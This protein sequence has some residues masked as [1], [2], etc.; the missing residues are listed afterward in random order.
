MRTDLWGL[1]K[2]IL[3]VC[4]LLSKFEQRSLNEQRLRVDGDIFYTDKKMPFQKYRDTC[5]RGLISNSW[6]SVGIL[7]G[8]LFGNGNNYMVSRER[9]V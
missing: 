2:G 5:G 8:H 4:F 3:I 9:Q 1:R 6:L 7:F